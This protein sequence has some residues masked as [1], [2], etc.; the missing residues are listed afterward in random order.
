MIKRF[1]AALLI[2]F[3]INDPNASVNTGHAVISLKSDLVSQ[4]KTIF[5]LQLI[6]KWMRDGIHTG[7]IQE[8]QVAL[9]GQLGLS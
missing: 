6:L 3:A 9:G 8:I 1:L 2:V 4:N 5:I 7:P